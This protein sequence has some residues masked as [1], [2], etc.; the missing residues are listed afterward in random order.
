[1]KS[2]LDSACHVLF[3]GLTRGSKHVWWNLLFWKFGLISSI[4][5]FVFSMSWNISQKPFD[6]KFFV[7]FTSSGTSPSFQ[8]IGLLINV[9]KFSFSLSSWLYLK[10]LKQWQCEHFH[11][12]CFLLL[13]IF[14]FD[15]NFTSSIIIFCFFT[16]H[17]PLPAN[18]LSVV[19]VCKMPCEF[20]TGR[21]TG[22]NFF[23]SVWTE[24]NMFIDQSQSWTDWRMWL[25]TD[26]NAHLLF[27]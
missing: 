2:S 18:S 3:Q 7:S 17:S 23:V 15:L 11:G 4:L 14:M 5:S 13:T 21:E 10:G 1:M 20:I 16:A 8:R 25:V 12:Q 27:R 26:Q 9:N 22:G 24:G 19:H 6:R